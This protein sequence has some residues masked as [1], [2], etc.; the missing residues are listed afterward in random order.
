MMLKVGD[1]VKLRPTVWSR[2]RLQ[3]DVDLGIVIKI[4]TVEMLVDEDY[5]TIRVHWVDGLKWNHLPD[6]LIKLS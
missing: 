6:A 5:T 4:S 2:A 1:L 3:G